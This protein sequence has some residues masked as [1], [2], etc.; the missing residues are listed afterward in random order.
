MFIKKYLGNP[1]R[2]RFLCGGQSIIPADKYVPMP[3]A[4]A[5]RQHSNMGRSPDTVTFTCNTPICQGIAPK[6]L[7]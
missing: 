6:G 3:Q 7:S 1:T 2:E 5:D 4:V